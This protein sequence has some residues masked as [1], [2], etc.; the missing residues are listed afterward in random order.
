MLIYQRVKTAAFAMGFPTEN[1]SEATPAVTP[2][3]ALFDQVVTPV[4]TPATWTTSPGSLELS[5]V[6]LGFLVK[7]NWKSPIEWKISSI[8]LFYNQYFIN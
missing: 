7:I 6:L 4:A 8:S 3:P 1:A 2:A 5:S